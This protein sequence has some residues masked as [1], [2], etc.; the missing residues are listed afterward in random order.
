MTLRTPPISTQVL[1]L[2][3]RSQ[4]WHIGFSEQLQIFGRRCEGLIGNGEKER[5]S[6]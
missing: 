1:P 4:G 3:R 5:R 2:Q 6:M